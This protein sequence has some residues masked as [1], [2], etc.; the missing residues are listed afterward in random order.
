M[1]ELQL[2]GGSAESCCTP[3]TADAVVDVAHWLRV[4]A[5]AW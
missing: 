3:A 5:E 1:V 4:S 2:Q